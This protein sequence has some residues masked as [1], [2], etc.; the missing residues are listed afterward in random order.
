RR[1]YCQARSTPRGMVK[2]V[3]RLGTD[4]RVEA[5]TESETLEHGEIHID[6]ARSAQVGRE[7]RRISESPV[8]DH[9]EDRLIE[10]GVQPLIDRALFL[11]RLAVVVWTLSG[12]ADA[13]V[14]A[15]VADG[16]R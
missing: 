14:V 11:R 12:I 2:E 1:I 7:S 8:A 10:I 9:R 15:S 16:K 4:L 5:F 13:D 3:E 6:R